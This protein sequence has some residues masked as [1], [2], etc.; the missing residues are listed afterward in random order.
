MKNC[1]NT[2]NF[3]NTKAFFKKYLF[4]P[5][6][7]FSSPHF[8]PRKDMHIIKMLFLFALCA[9]IGTS[10]KLKFI[11]FF[12]HLIVTLHQIREYDEDIDSKWT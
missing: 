9:H 1:K 8:L 6:I 4:S 7:F 5:L 3:P 11:W 12:S 2:L 10:E